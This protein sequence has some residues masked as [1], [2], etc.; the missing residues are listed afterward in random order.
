MLA[1][2][3]ALAAWPG[4]ALADGDPASDVLTETPV[5]FPA[6]AGIPAAR[7]VQLLKLVRQ[8][9]SRGY[10]LRVA[11]IAHPHPQAHRAA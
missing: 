4:R 1:L 3:I 7:Q 6:D 5:Y 2:A 8:A 10:P 9:A 11:L